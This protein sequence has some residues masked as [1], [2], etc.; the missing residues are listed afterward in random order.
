MNAALAPYLFQ[1]ELYRFSSPALVVI[2]SKNWDEYS[3]EEKNLLAKIL[4]SVKL[5]LASVQIISRTAVSLQALPS[6]HASK[7]LIFGSVADEIKLYEN[8]TAQSF[9]VIRA[10]DLA[11]LDDV[12]KKSLWLALKQ[13]F[14]I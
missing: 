12:K 5:D 1:E 9:S 3:S 6:L 13:M 2:V 4:G 7:V 14:G 10:D 8:T 11:R